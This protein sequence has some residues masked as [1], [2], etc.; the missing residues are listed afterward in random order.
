MQISFENSS[1]W[2]SKF[3][4]NDVGFFSLKD[5]GDQTIVRFLIDSTADLDIHV[6]HDIQLGDKYRK[7]ECIRENPSDPLDNCPLCAAGMPSKARAFIHMIQYTPE[8]PKAVIWEKT[9]SW[10]SESLIPLLKEYGPL[11][12]HLFKVVRH[13]KARDLRTTYNILFAPPTS[14]PPEQYPK[15]DLFGDFKVCGSFVMDKTADELDYFNKTGVFPE[16][17]AAQPAGGQGDTFDRMAQTPPPSFAPANEAF[18]QFARP[19]RY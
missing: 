9:L 3:T 10:V 8:G 17:D 19:E 12:D 13:G 5:D 11:S 1:A 4:G 15:D 16:K 7:V 14:C 6:V 2:T 18:S